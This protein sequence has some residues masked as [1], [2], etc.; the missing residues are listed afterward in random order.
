MNS[1]LEYEI[2]LTENLLKLIDYLHSEVGEK[3]WVY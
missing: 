2:E 3:E 1:L